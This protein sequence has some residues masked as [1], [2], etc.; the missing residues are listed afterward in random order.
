MVSVGAPVCGPTRL[1]HEI[2]RSPFIVGGLSRSRESGGKVPSMHACMN[3][4]VSACAK[5][6]RNEIFGAACDGCDRLEPSRPKPADFRSLG[7]SEGKNLAVRR[8]ISESPEPS[9]PHSTPIVRRA[10]YQSFR[11][12]TFHAGNKGFEAP[13]PRVA[14]S[15]PLRKQPMS[16]ALAW[17][18]QPNRGHARRNFRVTLIHELRTRPH[19]HR[20]HSAAASTTTTARILLIPT[21]TPKQTASYKQSC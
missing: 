15:G 8:Q 16:A 17:P 20:P 9:V 2:N 10:R 6:P 3:R 19:F 1:G 11:H 18:G 5:R 14:P 7:P 12:Q 21:A 4:R 13:P